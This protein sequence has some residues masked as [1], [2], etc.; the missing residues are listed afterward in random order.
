MK[1]NKILISLALMASF[2]LASCDNKQADSV[3]LIKDR[4]SVDNTPSTIEIPEELRPSHNPNPVIDN[5]LEDVPADA[6]DVEVVGEYKVLT[7]SSG[8]GF[9]FVGWF[10]GDKCV[11]TNVTYKALLTE[12]DSI[13]PKFEVKKGFEYFV[14]DSN[15]TDCV[16]K[17]IK[18]NCPLDLTVP[19]GVTEI[20]SYAF[21][22]SNCC[23]VTLPKSLKKLNDYAFSNSQIVR[24]TFNSIPEVGEYLFV[25]TLVDNSNNQGGSGLIP[26]IGPVINSLGVPI[27]YGT[28]IRREVYLNGSF[29]YNEDF[30]Y[31]FMDTVF[32]ESLADSVYALNTDYLFEFNEDEWRLSK[33]LGK[34]K[35]ITLPASTAKIAEYYIKQYAFS[36]SDVEKVTF[37]SAVTYVDTNAFEYCINLKEVKLNEGLNSIESGAFYRCDVLGEITIPSTVT[38]ISDYAFESC[39]SLYTIYNLSEL[40]VSDSCFGASNVMDVFTDT[41][42][43]SHVGIKDDFRYY[44]D[45]EDSTVILLEYLGNA[46]EVAIPSFDNYDIRFTNGLFRNNTVIE[47]VTLNNKVTFIGE[48]AFYG[49]KNLRSFDSLNLKDIPYQAFYECYSLGSI[50]LPNVESIGSYAFQYCAILNVIN[51][52]K[53]K[54]IGTYAF[55]GCKNIKQLELPET[56]T[57]IYDNAFYYCNSLIEVINKSGLSISNNYSNGSVGRYTRSIITDIAD[58]I[59][60]TENGFVYYVYS[61]DKILFDIVDKTTKKLV[62]PADYKYIYQGA[63]RGVAL[64]E[65][66]LNV[67]DNYLGYYFGAEYHDDSDGNVPDTLKKVILNEGITTIP[68]YAFYDCPNIE[69]TTIPST[70]TSIGDYAFEGANFEKLVLEEGVQYIG[71]NAFAYNNSLISVSL[72]TTL[73]TISSGAFYKCGLLQSVTIKEGTT[74]IGYEAFEDCKSLY[75]IVIPSTISSLGSSVFANC[76]TLE[77]ISLKETGVTSLPYSLFENCKNLVDLELP[78]GLQSIDST[79]FAGCDKLEGTVYKNG[80]YF[81]TQDNPYRWLVK[82]RAKTIVECTVHPDCEKIYSS[83]FINCY[84]LRKLVIPA[85]CTDFSY[86]LSGVTTLKSLEMPYDS[87]AIFTRLTGLTNAAIANLEELIINGGTIIPEKAF[88]NVTTLKTIVLPNTLTTINKNAFDGSGIESLELPSSFK[89]IGANAFQ[90]CKS[91]TSVDMSNTGVTT[92]PTYA[93]YNCTKLKTVT[94]PSTVTSISTYTFKWC[95]DLESINLPENLTSIGSYAFQGCSSLESITLPKKLDTINMYAFNNTSLKSIDLSYV[96]TIDKYAFAGTDIESLSILNYNKNNYKVNIKNYAF[97]NCTKLTTLNYNNETNNTNSDYFRNLFSGC[98]ALSDVTLGSS[99]AIL[100]EY[101]FENCTSLKTINLSK[102][103]TIKDYAFYGSGLEEVNI[104]SGTTVKK[105]AFEKCLNLVKV[106]FNNDANI[107]TGTFIDCEKLTTVVLPTVTKLT[108]IPYDTFKGCK[109]LASFDF[110]DVKSIGE[111]AFAD[112]GFEELTIPSTITVNDKAFSNSVKLTKVVLNSPNVLEYVFQ[113]CTKLDDVTFGEDFGDT[114]TAGLFYGCSS[115]KSIEIPNNIKTVSAYSFRESGLEEITIPSSVEKLQ[116]NTF[117][118]CTNLKKAVIN[119]KCVGSDIFYRCFNLTEVI[120]GDGT[121]ELGGDMFAYDKSLAKIT[122]PSTL[123]KIGYRAFEYC[124]ALTSITIP[125][126][127]T[128]I[129]SVLGRSETP[130]SDPEKNY[131]LAFLGCYNLVEVYNLSSIEIVAG[132]KINNGGIGWN[133]KVVHTSIDDA[134]I[135]VNKDDYVFSY[136]NNVATLVTYIGQDEDL[137][138]PDS[139]TVNGQNITSYVIKDHAFDRNLGAVWTLKSQYKSIKMSN[140]VKAISEHSFNGCDRLSSVE[141]PNGLTEIPAGAFNGCSSLTSITIPA[142]VT[143]IASDAFKWC[144]KLVQVYNLSNATFPAGTISTDGYSLMATHKSLDEKSIIEKD[145]NGYL[146]VLYNNV[147]YVL[148]CEGNYDELSLPESLTYNGRTY[149]SYEL[150]QYSF[151]YNGA[152]KVIIPN[153]VSKVG[154]MAFYYAEMNELA[155]SSSINTDSRISNDAFYGCT[156]VTSIVIPAFILTQ[157]DSSADITSLTLTCGTTIKA[158]AFNK[159]KKLRSI[160][161]PKTITTI[162]SYSFYDSTIDYIFYMGTSSDKTSISVSVEGS[163]AHYLEIKWYYYSE[164]EPVAAGSYWH[165]D[166]SGNIVIW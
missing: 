134:S 165:Y 56:L 166:A 51:F 12:A 25:D 46:K 159:M 164:T 100:G 20:G 126:S 151:M 82:A 132:D 63:L 92:I 9:D 152:K 75:T 125:A 1:K 33:Y 55:Y 3:K 161:L 96:R 108:T 24:L 90:N 26:Y 11:S 154:K 2:G 5:E 38:Y 15:E 113:G 65:L 6:Y 106:T 84:K 139:F 40:E 68:E 130:N 87:S 105:N 150:Y 114:I 47:K 107:S 158:Y 146:L 27:A 4:G 32:L 37:T 59:L 36:N 30:A 28:S 62:I 80:S 39:D 70:V 148:G 86:C 67:M 121:E 138:L 54:T 127:V 57:D 73:E 128:E 16:I 49:C 85:T 119:G 8:I 144:R 69:E 141:L 72:P 83:A 45:V 58:S 137:V 77:S 145:S 133:A 120:F 112:T 155:V 129:A 66:T 21:S 34:E 157:F 43:K 122:L 160:V 118:L 97:A 23:F 29:E 163:N 99:C 116:N 101:M 74:S 95:H 111:S 162:E 64:E 98:S 31:A 110:T 143:T 18:D 89:T 153:A 14:F 102:V 156:K 103:G 140:A 117:E 35:E 79:T 19:E 42:S 93:F 147:L 81:G 44:E 131:N 135:L 53:V 104:A 50:N 115:L 17:E 94:L 41:T 10:K 136:F 13:E 123:K 60:K 142:S 48:G 124:S 7:A 78:A 52:P 71:R 76:E 22:N 88:Q 91:L 61:D 109:S 149:T